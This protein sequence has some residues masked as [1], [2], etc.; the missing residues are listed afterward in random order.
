MDTRP[1]DRRTTSTRELSPVTK[2][3]YAKLEYLNEIID[4][5]INIYDP[6]R[7][8]KD[9]I[10]SIL[11]YYGFTVNYDYEILLR[12]SD[13]G[14][15]SLV[16]RWYWDNEFHDESWDTDDK[17]DWDIYANIVVAEY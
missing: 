9:I 15:K 12:N 3:T 10:I 13:Y 5:S 2:A 7:K 8:T 11:S 16:I 1:T 14:T 17:D 6:F 4:E